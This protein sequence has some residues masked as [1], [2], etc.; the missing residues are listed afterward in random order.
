[1]RRPI[2][3]I[4]PD[5]QHGYALCIVLMMMVVIALLVVTSTQS[6]NTEQRIS[7]ND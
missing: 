1:M 7:T 5:Q 2:T 4:K 3:L 6:Y